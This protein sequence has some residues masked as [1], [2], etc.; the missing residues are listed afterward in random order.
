MARGTAKRSGY[1]GYVWLVQS[2]TAIFGRPEY[3]LVVQ[4][5]LGMMASLALFQ[6]M[7]ERTSMPVAAAGISIMPPTGTLLS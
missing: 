3:V 1:R 4:W 2:S 7:L 5:L 6:V